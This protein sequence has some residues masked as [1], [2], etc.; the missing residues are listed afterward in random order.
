V[1]STTMIRDKGDL[2]LLADGRQVTVRSLAADDAAALVTAVE[3]ED[4]WDLRRRFMGTP[5]PSHVLV[6][7]LLRADG[8]HDLAIGA[9]TD[10]GQLVGLAQFDRLDDGPSAEI[11]IE[12]SHEWQRIGLCTALLTTLVG[13][14]RARGVREFTATYYGDNVAIRRLLHDIGCAVESGFDHGAGYAR[15]NLG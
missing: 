6:K 2:V 14:A 4:P 7:Q 5:P 13:L 10:D 15:I 12:V 11:A 8:F 9:F 1:S 3:H